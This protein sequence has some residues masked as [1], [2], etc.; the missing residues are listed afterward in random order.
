MEAEL[1]RWRRGR[2][3]ACGAEDASD[4][5]VAREG[6]WIREDHPNRRKKSAIKNLCFDTQSKNVSLIEKENV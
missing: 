5:L 4:Q 6:Q 3:Y 1:R 2:D